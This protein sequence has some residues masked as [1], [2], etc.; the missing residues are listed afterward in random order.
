VAIGK[1]TELKAIAVASG[2]AASPVTGG[3]YTIR[4]ATPVFNPPAGTYSTTQSVTIASSTQSAAIYYTTDGTTPTTSSTLYSAPVA[5][6]E[7]TTLKAMA[8]ATGYAQSTSSSATY[9]IR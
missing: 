1:N 7:N 9:T 5:V 3:Y 2:Y 8:L 6:S 4:A